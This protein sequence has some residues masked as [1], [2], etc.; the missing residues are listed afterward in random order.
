MEIYDYSGIKR[1]RSSTCRRP[2]SD[3]SNQIQ[4]NQDG[5][6]L[7]L[8]LRKVKLKLGGVS[9]H[10]NSS[11]RPRPQL[12]L[13]DTS[14]EDHHH[15]SPLRKSK[16]VPRPRL[17]DT[18]VDVVD[19][20]DTE[21]TEKHRTIS[22]VSE[23]RGDYASVG[24]DVKKTHSHRNESFDTGGREML[25]TTRQRALQSLSGNGSAQNFIE[26]PNGLPPQLPRKQK[27]SV[28][29]SEVDQQLKKAEAAQRR[30]MQV[31]KAARESQAEAIRKILGQDS[32]RKKREDRNKKLRD[33]IAQE[34]AANSL[35]LPPNTIRWTISPTGTV[36]TFP[37]EMGLPSI[38]SSKP[39]SYPPP[40]EKCAGPSCTNAY[41][42]RD[43][44]SNLPLCSLHCYKA[45]NGW[46]HP[47]STF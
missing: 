40:R 11:S 38:F 21:P 25:L 17:L 28:C 47:V 44:K 4:I 12:V 10:P 8:K 6:K 18:D 1:K 7:K 43:S 39:C 33:E 20:D 19:D 29:V 31:E 46:V 22:S 45:V 2:R 36:V 24:S 23:S 9:I 5:H 41:K 42:Y 26:F 3:S 16:R 34:K 14:D 15:N 13:Q 30:R 35:T 32:T 27:E 37:Q